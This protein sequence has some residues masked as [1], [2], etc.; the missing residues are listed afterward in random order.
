MIHDRPEWEAIERNFR[1]YQDPRGRKLVRNNHTTIIE[2]EFD[3][4]P[5][6]IGFPSPVAHSEYRYTGFPS[7]DHGD[8]Y[9]QR[10]RN[11][12]PQKSSGFYQNYP[13][14]PKPQ[15]QSRD[16]DIEEIL[17]EDEE[18]D[19]GIVAIGNKTPNATV[20]PSRGNSSQD[21]LMNGELRF[22]DQ[23]T[24]GL[25]ELTELLKTVPEKQ[26]NFSYNRN[27]TRAQVVRTTKNIAITRETFVDGRYD[28]RGHG[29][30]KTVSKTDTWSP[31]TPRGTVVVPPPPTEAPRTGRVQRTAFASRSNG[32]HRN[33]DVNRNIQAPPPSTQSKLLPIENGRDTSSRQTLPEPRVGNDIPDGK[34]STR[35]TADRNRILVNGPGVSDDRGV[36]RKRVQRIQTQ[37]TVEVLPLD[38]RNATEIP[39]YDLA[40]TSEEDD[41]DYPLSRE[42][43]TLYEPDYYQQ[44][45]PGPGTSNSTAEFP[46]AHLH[47]TRQPYPTVTTTADPVATTPTAS[48]RATATGFARNLKPTPLPTRTKPRT[49]TWQDPPANQR[50]PTS[51]EWRSVASSTT[52]KP[53]ETISRSSSQRLQK[54][55]KVCDHK[56]CQFVSKSP[57]Y[58]KPAGRTTAV[59]TVATTV[60]SP[61]TTPGPFQRDQVL[62]RRPMQSTDAPVMKRRV[63]RKRK[64]VTAA[65]SKG[66][67]Y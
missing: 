31:V 51:R 58:Q 22:P 4:S 59:P 33:L 35:D 55:A 41:A 34:G 52:P 46:Q 47:P 62:S 48:P 8:W 21:F 26:D 12:A 42:H 49:K 23:N 28:D 2:E 20:S 43:E 9:H 32:N 56:N 24:G 66:E 10:H 27:G 6:E 37:S 5:H 19:V 53:L 30:A 40:D 65:P 60:A 7:Y 36:V 25:R 63:R 29:P 16:L 3:K 11:P 67:A 15:P 39:I 13:S 54:P 1:D 64:K 45:T 57:V 18:A 17:S 50:L 44:D 14:P 61:I 38:A